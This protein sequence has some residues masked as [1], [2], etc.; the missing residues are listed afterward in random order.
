MQA[1]S[2]FARLEPT[3]PRS[4]RF[5]RLTLTLAGAVFALATVL[6]GATIWLCLTE[7]VTVADAV[8]RGEWAATAKVVFAML[9]SGLEQIVRYL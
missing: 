7:P 6:A 5:A 8:G 2:A 9:L 3:P 1:R 4:S